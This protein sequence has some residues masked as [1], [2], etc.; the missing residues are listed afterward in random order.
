MSPSRTVVVEG[1]V[2]GR[3]VCVDAAVVDSE[4]AFVSVCD[5]EYVG[6]DG[7]IAASATYAAVQPDRAAAVSAIR[8]IA[9]V[10]GLRDGVMQAEYKIDGDR[11]VLLEV[12][13]RPGGA[14]VP[15]LTERVT[16]VNLYEVQA[17]LALG[18][19]PAVP[20]PDPARSPVP[21]AQVRF[22]VGSGHVRA[23][24]PPARVLRGLPDVKIVNQF[25]RAGQRVRLPLSEDGRAGYAVGWGTDRERLD[26]Q[27]R[28]AVRRLGREMGIAELRAGPVAAHA[29]DA[30]VGSVAV[31]AVGPGVP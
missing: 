30:A 6:P 18:L 23:F 20:A 7:F 27:L 26:G 19:T 28:E 1:F 10:Y 25:V 2:R 17:C 22:L 3:E 9:S 24:V 31:T 11:W 21:F 29:P 14:L 15:D 4:P 13:F 12:T 8:R 5:A 16:G